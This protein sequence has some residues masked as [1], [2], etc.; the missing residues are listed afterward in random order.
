[1]NILGR[2]TILPSLLLATFLMLPFQVSA[3]NN[4]GEKADNFDI[5]EEPAHRETILDL[6]F[7]SAPA[8]ATERGILVINAFDDQ[9]NSGSRDPDE[10]ELR[11]EIVCTIDK[12]DYSIPA[13]IP[14]LDYNNHYEVR[15]R[16]SNF[17]PTM[18]DKKILVE[19]RGDIIELDLPC[20]KIQNNSA[21]RNIKQAMKSPSK[22]AP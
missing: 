21:Q 22:S 9:N 11:K 18:P 4:E 15:C 6:F 3:N 1:M 5:R 19:H 12:I 14:G 8:L 10:P 17:Y 7:G 20:R 16:G 13:F 2:H